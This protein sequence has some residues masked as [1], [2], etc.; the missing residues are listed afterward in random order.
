MVAA[1]EPLLLKA[2]AA[3]ELLS[4]G[5]RTLYS[6]SKRGDIPRVKFGR[7]VRYIKADLE[8]WVEKHKTSGMLVS[9]PSIV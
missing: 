3:A 1:I 5:G 7:M 2:P 6:M 4:V 8:A 9:M